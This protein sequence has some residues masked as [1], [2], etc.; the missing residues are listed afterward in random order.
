MLRRLR[1]VYANK[2]CRDLNK[3]MNLIET[4]RHY[5]HTHTQTHTHTHTHTHRR[6]RRST[7]QF[8]VRRCRFNP[9]PQALNPNPKY[10]SQAPNLDPE[11]GPRTWTPNSQLISACTRTGPSKGFMLTLDPAFLISRPALH[12]LT[13]FLTSRPH[14]T[15]TRT[16]TSQPKSL[17]PKRE[18]GRG[19]TEALVLSLTEF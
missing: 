12:S 17:N 16:R 18:S 6:R 10:R 7:G 13:A 14:P 1:E 9:K 19:M 8:D 15:H 11:P 2:G 3:T 4:I 5:T